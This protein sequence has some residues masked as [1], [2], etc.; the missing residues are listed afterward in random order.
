MA[1]SDADY[2]AWLLRRSPGVLLFEATYSYLWQGLKLVTTGGDSVNLRAAFDSPPAL[3]SFTVIWRGNVAALEDRETRIR[4]GTATKALRVGWD[5]SGNLWAEL[6]DGTNTASG[7]LGSP[8]FATGVHTFAWVVDRD[9]DTI[10]GYIDGAA[11]GATL[12]IS[13]VTGTLDG[14][15]EFY[16]DDNGVASADV[17]N[18][19]VYDTV[20]NYQALSAQ[21]VAD[22]YADYN[23]VVLDDLVG[24]WRVHSGYTWNSSFQADINSATYINAGTH[25]RNDAVADLNGVGPDATPFTFE[26]ADDAGTENLYLATAAYVSAAADTPA[27]TPYDER[28]INIPEYQQQLDGFM[29][30]SKT[31][32]GSIRLNNRDG[33]LNYLLD[34]DWQSD[35]AFEL[36]YGDRGWPKSDYRKKLKGVIVGVTATTD[37]IILQLRDTQQRIYGELID[38]PVLYGEAVIMRPALVSGKTYRVSARAIFDTVAAYDD[39]FSVSIA[40]K[41]N[42][43]GEFT[44]TNTPVGD[45]TCNAI[46]LGGAPEGV[47]DDI[48]ANYTPLTSADTSISSAGLITTVDFISSVVVETNSE[49][50][51]SKAVD[52]LA[53]SGLGACYTG[54]DGLITLR[55]LWHGSDAAMTLGDDDI[56]AVTLLSITPPDGVI[57]VNYQPNW[58]PTDTE[59]AKMVGRHD[60]LLQILPYQSEDFSDT[61]L[62]QWPDAQPFTIDLW[63]QDS[64]APSIPAPRTWAALYR[65]FFNAPWQVWQVELTF[66]AVTTNIYDW[67]V[68]QALPYWANPRAGLVI[69]L[70]DRADNTTVLT[71]LV[72]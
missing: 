63:G 12:D 52:Q 46:G 39:G 1:I 47:I 67:L 20:V 60:E 15:A 55:H 41:D 2:E 42:A 59:V 44:L 61:I 40:S 17:M 6:D 36:F 38:E 37:E 57:T 24:R 9:A 5:T 51:V 68:L 26:D 66:P 21:Q 22:Y 49:M 8:T 50:L 65:S 29:G 10:T 28:V 19:F 4:L 34:V 3:G 13:T 71:V 35:N 58:G 27:S 54:R 31:T 32:L 33:A 48:I 25:H 11:T 53:R 16:W 7:S 30:L 72:R 62:D 64:G 69:G 56:A 14:T 45:V 18:A 70:S 23:Q 43:G